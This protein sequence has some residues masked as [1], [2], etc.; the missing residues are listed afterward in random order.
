MWAARMKADGG[1]SLARLTRE[2]LAK[3]K[4]LKKAELAK[5]QQSSKPLTVDRIPR[6]LLP[7]D[8]LSGLPQ[9]SDSFNGMQ[10]T[11]QTGLM[12][13]KSKM[14]QDKGLTPPV[15]RAQLEEERGTGEEE[16]EESKEKE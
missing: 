14:R 7:V 1:A 15:K 3:A 10:P 12:P 4:Q 2:Q 13:A 16:E 6:N 11:S 8:L 5:L 9:D